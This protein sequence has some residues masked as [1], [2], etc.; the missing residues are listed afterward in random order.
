MQTSIVPASG[1]TTYLLQPR[2]WLVTR[3]HA[4]NRDKASRPQSGR[5]CAR[6]RRERVCRA[7]NGARQEI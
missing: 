7:C 4:G 1:H 6:C 5:R 2:G 3:R